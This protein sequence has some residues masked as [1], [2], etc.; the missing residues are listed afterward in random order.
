MHRIGLLLKS[1]AADR[2]YVERLLASFHV[3]NREGLHLHCVVPAADHALFRPFSAETVTV[4]DE[5]AFERYFTD[6]SVHGLRPGYINQEIVKLAFWETGLLENYF[7]VDSEAVFVRPFGADDFM[8]DEET[9]YTILVEDNELKVE[10]EYYRAHWVGREVAI[11]RIMS[12]VGVD[13]PVMRTCHGHQVM[14]SAVLSSFVEDFL[15]PRGWR[16]LDALR[17]SPYEFSWYNMWLQKSRVIPI[18]AREPFVKVF[19]NEAQEMEYILRGV[20]PADIARGYLAVVVNSNY[21]RQIAVRGPGA[22]FGVSPSGSMSSR[23]PSKAEQLAPHLS[24]PELVALVEAKL[25]SSLKALSRRTRERSR[26]D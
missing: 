6:E 26:L 12:A 5:S 24:Y 1:Y 15:R 11:R 16:Y 2:D 21:A 13:D 25:T 23:Q 14:S 20:G 10:P 18:H 3:H 8:R 9:P 7:C 4:H 19:H 17:E 22:G